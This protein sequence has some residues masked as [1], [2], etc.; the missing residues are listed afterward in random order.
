MG[1]RIK[2]KSKRLPLMARDYKTVRRTEIVQFFL[3][4][5]FP[6]A[7][8]CSILSEELTEMY[9]YTDI[10]WSMVFGIL[11]GVLVVLG[12]KIW[13]ALQQTKVEEPEANLRKAQWSPFFPKPTGK[14]AQ[15]HYDESP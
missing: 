1:V 15:E 13:E 4:Y 10:F 5:T 14:E 8:R 11:G 3:S 12:F 7:S 9:F 2:G 6:S